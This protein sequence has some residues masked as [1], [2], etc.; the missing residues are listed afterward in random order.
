M[1]CRRAEDMF[2]DYLYGELKPHRAEPLRAHLDEC[3]ACRTRLAELVR[4]RQ[5]VAQVPDSE[6]SP[7]AINRVIGRAREEEERSRSIL[8]SRW[9]KVL[10][11]LCL[12][13]VIGGLVAY[14]FRA[15]LAPKPMAYAPA[16]EEQRAAAQQPP[17]APEPEKKSSSP[18]PRG[19][20]KLTAPALP[21]RAS[22]RVALPSAPAAEP[23]A[24]QVAPPQR[25]AESAAPRPASPEA[26][27]SAREEA[28]STARL[29]APEGGAERPPVEATGSTKLAAAPHQ[30]EK[31]VRDKATNL[32]AGEKPEALVA[33]L[34]R[35][36]E[37][38]LEAGRY[39]EASQAFSQ[40]LKLLQPADPDRSRALLGLAR[41]QEGQKDLTTAIRTY[42]ELAQESSAYR[43]L[44]E[45]KIRELT[46][47]EVK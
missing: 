7:I 34:L 37:R 24:A 14:Q 25:A 44:A 29:S 31:A 47:S 23:G 2:I 4:V 40:A 33:N 30:P 5:L 35:Q 13:V 42:R 28:P 38:S 8:S 27:T 45:R 11:P 22:P 18:V 21:R 41:A 16:K 19:P 1:N 3:L 6:P 17:P 20:G 15:G 46:A 26:F 32:A 10:A 12:A 43:D 39:G 9:L 36:G